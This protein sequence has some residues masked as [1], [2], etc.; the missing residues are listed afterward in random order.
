MKAALYAMVTEAEQVQFNFTIIREGLKAIAS[1]NEEQLLLSRH[2]LEHLDD[3]FDPMPLDYLSFMEEK[4]AISTF[5]ALRIRELY[6]KVNQS[7]GHLEWK[8]QDAF[9]SQNTKELQQWRQIAQGLLS[10]L[11]GV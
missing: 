10:E 11:N 6:R 9:I 3:V 4:N 5:L 8:E 7:I 1:E 2:G